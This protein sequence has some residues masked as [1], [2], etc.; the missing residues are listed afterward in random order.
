MSDKKETHA[1]AEATP[2]GLVV[3]KFGT[4][5]GNEDEEP[6]FTTRKAGSWELETQAAVDFLASLSEAVDEA[7]TNLASHIT[8]T[9]GTDG[10]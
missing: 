6:T 8:N 9:G 5:K 1:V 4:W 7:T 10:D 2:E 3:V